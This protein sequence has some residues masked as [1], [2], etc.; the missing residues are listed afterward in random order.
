MAQEKLVGVESLLPV[1]PQ[2]AL[3]E[4]L[5]VEKNAFGEGC[6]TEY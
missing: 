3:V 2:C 1:S 4:C 5:L 6:V